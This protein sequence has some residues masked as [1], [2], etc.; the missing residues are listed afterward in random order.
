MHRGERRRRSPGASTRAGGPESSGAGDE[1][2]TACVEA[3]GA[4]GISFGGAGRGSAALTPAA[5]AL[6]ETC[7]SDFIPSLTLYGRLTPSSEL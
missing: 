7:S 4:R 6:P 1:F 2:E 3:E 5:A